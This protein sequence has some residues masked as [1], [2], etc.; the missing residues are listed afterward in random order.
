MRWRT[1]A[2]LSSSGGRS[3]CSKSSA[4]GFGAGAAALLAGSVFCDGRVLRVRNTYT[5]AASTTITTTPPPISAP[6]GMDGPR[7]PPELGRGA[8]G[9]LK[10]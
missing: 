6:R 3:I 8:S 5:A 2:S 10:S 4:A 7:P 1:S 9:A